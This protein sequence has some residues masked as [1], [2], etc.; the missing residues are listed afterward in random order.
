MKMID[1]IEINDDFVSINNVALSREDISSFSWNEQGFKVHV[2]M[3]SGHEH[4]FSFEDHGAFAE[5]VLR[6]GK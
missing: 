5:A 2:L 4:S 1:G 3:K 6:L